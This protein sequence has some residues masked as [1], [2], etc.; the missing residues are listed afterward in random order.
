MKNILGKCPVMFCILVA[1]LQTGCRTTLLV[2]PGDVHKPEEL[3][4]TA[5]AKQE[6]RNFDWKIAHSD[7]L[8]IMVG[9]RRFS[10]SDTQV[11]THEFLYPIIPIV[12]WFGTNR[13]ISSAKGRYHYEGEKGWAIG[14]LIIPLPAN[15]GDVSL[16]RDSG[17]SFVR[18]LLSLRYHARNTPLLKTAEPGAIAAAPA[19][20]PVT[21]TVSPDD[22]GDYRSIMEALASSQ[23][24]DVILLRS[25][26]HGEAYINI[27]GIKIAGEDRDKVRTGQLVIG[28]RAKD[29]VI[30]NLTVS[31]GKEYAGI[32]VKEASRVEIKDCA[33]NGSHDGIFVMVSNDVRVEG[34]VIQS[35]SGSGVAA[36]K[37]YGLVIEDTLVQRN[38]ES[39]ITLNDVQG[40]IDHT[41]VV[42]H[43]S[44][45]GLI[46][47]PG[48]SVSVYNSIVA[49]NTGGIWAWSDTTVEYNN[50]FK[51]TSGDYSVPE[52][53][54]TNKSEDPFFM[55][56]T[57]D[58]RLRPESPLVNKGRGG[59][60]IGA[61]PPE[62]HPKSEIARL[63]SI[64]P[65]SVVSQLDKE[66]TA[67]T[68]D[69]KPPIKEGTSWAVVVGIGNYEDSRI[70]NLAFAPDDARMF[71]AW[72]RRSGWPEDHI[73]CLIDAEAKQRDVKIALESWLTKAKPNDLIVFYW[74]GH[75]FHDPEDPERV[76][77]ACHDTNI[78]IPATG[79][80]MD[81][82]IRILKERKAKNVVVLAD[83][84][85]AGKLVT[86]GERG[87]SVVPALKR[88]EERNKV[89][90]GWVFMVSA[91]TDR[92]AV[93]DSSWRNGAFTHCLLEGLEGKADGFQSIGPKDS[94]VTLGELRA[95]L[96]SIMPDETQKVLGVAKHP[97]I[98]TSTGD[99]AIW[100]LSLQGK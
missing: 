71:A 79:F 12:V 29:V 70:P 50:A 45:W 78:R 66:Q 68:T 27:P 74:S 83:T 53:A 43:N 22:T 86:R 26:A 13:S 37:T 60:Y 90:K 73:R 98:T 54:A 3:M 28:P 38:G 75:G 7:S 47:D 33:I 59:T 62:D 81:Q 4:S 14:Y 76:Y 77:F 20:E 42:R 72:L 69:P 99:A 34:C 19:R 10:Y 9:P 32:I 94:T 51:N 52:R 63:E 11:R 88:M 100:D 25:G 97:L 40:T 30:E 48:S 41:T 23:A 96:T 67:T 46:A 95:Y 36:T 39:G 82:V 56:V 24:G 64:K 58:Y 84:C 44:G 5:Q 91:E 31:A 16:G 8:G 87:L 35:N 6:L 1:L 80:R 21:V 85:H 89:P 61:F 49:F 18:A 93:E 55:N 2:K 15:K 92:K 57:N 65:S 17:A